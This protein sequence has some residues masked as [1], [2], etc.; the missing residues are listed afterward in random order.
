[1]GRRRWHALTIWGGGIAILAGLAGCGVQLTHTATAST[2]A[3]IHT[4]RMRI[5]RWNSPP[6]MTINP[7]LDYLATVKTSAGSF[8]IQLFS[9]SDPVA[10]N[11]F[12]FLARHQ[13]FNGDQ[14]FRVLKSFVIQTG[15]PLNNGTGGPGYTWKAELPPPV[16]YQP[17]IVAMA[18]NPSN[19]NSNG[20]QFFICTGPES[21]ALNQTP[22][23]TEVGRVVSGWNTIEAIAAGPV[24]VNPLTGEDSAPL[25]P[26]K[27]L[28][29]TIQTLP[30]GAT[31]T[32]NSG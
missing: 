30:A 9:R 10:A 3:K 19:V 28:S 20:S 6:P 12:V 24:K 14:F 16:P 21:E 2:S 11:N 1:M 23:Y 17:G 18:I 4:T 22:E 31:G 29:V 32:T 15:D 27:I 26:Q 7:R 8:T 13:F 25:H 5:L